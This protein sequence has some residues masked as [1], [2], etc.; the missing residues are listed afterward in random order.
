MLNAVSFG[1]I[2]GITYWKSLKVELVSHAL[3]HSSVDDNLDSLYAEL[4]VAS[5]ISKILA[6]AIVLYNKYLLPKFVH[7]IVDGERWP[8]KTD[9]NIS[10]GFYLAFSLFFNSGIIS[11]VCEV[12][13]LNN[14]YNVGGLMYGEWYLFLLNAI[15]PP[16]TFLVDPW[17]WCKLVWRKFQ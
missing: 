13:I 9:S 8:T 4:D 1:V 3:I 5:W 14:C 12:I 16:V 15:I 11:F 6:T 17:Y 7:T 10:F 2:L